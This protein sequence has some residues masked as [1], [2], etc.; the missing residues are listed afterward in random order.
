M[1]P[2]LVHVGT[3]AHDHAMVSAW[4]G[5][6]FGEFNE[7]WYRMGTD[8][9]ALLLAELDYKPRPRDTYHFATEED[10]ALF[11]LRWS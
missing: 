8:P 7:G 9:M 1:N 6:N 2:K 5:E 3:T 11:L 10:L 4:C